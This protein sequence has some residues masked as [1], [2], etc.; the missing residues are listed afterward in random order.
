MLNMKAASVIRSVIRYARGGEFY[1]NVFNTMYKKNCLIMYISSPFCNSGIT[2]RHQ[3]ERQILEIADIFHELKYNV[4]VADYTI[5]RIPTLKKYDVVFDINVKEEAAYDTNLKMD[6]KL[7]AYFTGSNPSFSNMAEKKRLKDLKCRKGVTLR[8]RRQAPTYSKRIQECTSVIFIGNQY[9]FKTYNNFFLKQH[10]L[11]NNTGYDF[12]G[13]L[14]FSR[15]KNNCFMYF[16][17]SGCVHK[18]L[19]LLLDVFSEKEFPC[20]L[21]VCGNYKKEKDFNK[22]YYKELYQCDNIKSFGF[23]DIHSSTFFDICNRCTFTILPS[24]SEGMAGSITTCMSAGLIPIVSKRCGF[25]V[26]DS[27]CIIELKDCQLNTIRQTVLNCM[28]M[29]SNL[30]YQ[31]RLGILKLVREEYSMKEFR[32]KMKTAI[33]DSLTTIA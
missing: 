11:V 5:K 15:K 7:I 26:D 8:A 18:G 3:N 10:F 17:S 31:K 9:N 13:R 20:E 1:N 14:D 28:E 32:R 21:Y 30:L 23:V 12:T 19:D 25:D 16:G 6:S 24:C 4:D 22:L 33:I 2:D 29:N 27:N